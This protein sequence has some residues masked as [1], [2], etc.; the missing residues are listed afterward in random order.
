MTD[1][2]GKKFSKIVDLNWEIDHKTDSAIEKFKKSVV[3][4]AMIEDL[5]QDMGEAEYNIFIDAG[6]R[7][8]APV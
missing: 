1:K 5:K 2:Q 7:M 4:N 6:R 8:F 3:L